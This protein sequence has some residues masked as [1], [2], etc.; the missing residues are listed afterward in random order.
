MAEWTIMLYMAADNNLEPAVARDLEELRSATIDSRI[1]VIVQVDTRTSSAKRYRVTK[2]TLELLD[3]L[4]ELDMS[5]PD[6][7]RNFVATVLHDYPATK[8]ALIMWGHGNGWLSRVDKKIYAVA[9]D[10][11]GGGSRYPMS[12]RALSQ[13]LS[14]A[15]L[16][17][18]QGID[19]L[20]FDACNMAT[21]EAVFEFRSIA[22]YLVA[23]QELVQGNGWNY[24][25][26]LARFSANPEMGAEEGA[27][28]IVQS[29]ADY[30]ES[31]QYGFG[32]QTISAI[33][34]GTTIE[35]LALEVD[36]LAQQLL[37][38]IDNPLNSA[39]TVLKIKAARSNVQ[40]FDQA[41]YPGMY[42]DLLDF[43][44]KLNATQAIASSVGNAV[45]HEYHGNQRPN[46]YGISIVFVDRAR[47]TSYSARYYFDDY[48]NFDPNTGSGSQSSFINLY[49]WDE[50]L[51]KYYLYAGL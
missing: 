26:L 27:K 36:K 34:L 38:D 5:N 29:Y 33:R 16:Q 32:D 23:S 17:T 21:L 28:L 24:N 13:A 44:Y 9:E 42:V 49:S 6:T 37:T 50:F 46:A 15:R 12:N 20:G 19:I 30:A 31:T 10:L 39:N 3:D 25:D 11:S 51:T 48:I 14:D 35:V 40:E 43:S 41:S 2:G 18:G 45:V 47:V 4:G 1:N 22:T 7:I 8:S